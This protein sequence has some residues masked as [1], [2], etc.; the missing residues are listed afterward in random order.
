MFWNFLISNQYVTIWGFCVTI[1]ISIKPV[2]ELILLQVL[3]LQ[4]LNIRFLLLLR[5][6]Y[7]SSKRNFC[8]S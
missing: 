5:L 4:R 3:T 8:S 7:H 1:K 6:F 2:L